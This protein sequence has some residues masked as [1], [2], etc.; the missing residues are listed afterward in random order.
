MDN[1]APFLDMIS[2][3]EGTTGP[4]GYRALFGY[5]PT[6]SKIFDNGYVW[7]PNVRVM[8]TQTDGTINYSTAAGRYQILFGTWARVAGKIGR[9]MFAPIDQ[10]AAAAELIAE[11]GAMPSV[12]SGD[13]QRAI[14][15]C[16]PVWA[17][18]PASTYPQPR[19]TLAFASDAFT[20][21]GGALA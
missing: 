14:D 17:S 4:D 18:L 7:H 12:K 11:T 6:N 2:A 8:F 15:L 1:L 16:S 9:K 13:L 3:C 21:A 5:T 20:S 10:D 19:R